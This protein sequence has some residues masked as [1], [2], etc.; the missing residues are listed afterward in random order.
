MSGTAVAFI[1]LIESADLY[2]RAVQ[3]VR[4][5]QEAYRR[6]RLTPIDRP[7]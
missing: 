2:E 6:R 1:D 5:E 3:A 7:C 4:R